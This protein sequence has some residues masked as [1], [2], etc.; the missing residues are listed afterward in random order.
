MY[1]D[2][3]SHQEAYQ[4]DPSV[5]MRGVSVVVPFRHEPEHQGCEEGGHRIYLRFDG[6][7]PECVAEAECECSDGSGSIYGNR[8]GNAEDF[9]F[10]EPSGEEYDGQVEQHYGEGGADRAE[11]VYC[12]RRMHVVREDGEESGEELEDRVPWRVAD[13]KLVGRCDEFSAVPE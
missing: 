10:H 11:G 1:P 5:C 7:E 9:R 13:F 3:K 2:R 6:G 12:R 8:L 4:D